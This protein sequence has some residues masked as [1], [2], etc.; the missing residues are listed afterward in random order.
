MKLVIIEPYGWALNVCLGE[1]DAKRWRAKYWPDRP[2][3]ED[4]RRAA[5][6]YLDM[7][8]DAQRDRR[9]LMMLPPTLCHSILAHESLHCAIWMMEESGQL[10]DF[11]TQEG[12]AYSQGHIMELILKKCWPAE[13]KRER[14]RLAVAVKAAHKE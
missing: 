5:L 6:G 2:D 11:D 4:P 3:G 8:E 9:W 14:A 10:A 7:Y 13:H 1:Q 12:L